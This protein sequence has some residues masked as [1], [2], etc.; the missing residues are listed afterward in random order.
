MAKKDERGPVRNP[1]PRR[2]TGLNP[3]Q[4]AF[5][6][7]FIADPDA[8]QAYVKAGYDVKDE[9]VAASAGRRLLLNVAVLQAI[10][11][12]RLA[13]MKRQSLDADAVVQRYYAL[14][15][16]ATAEKDWTAACMALRDVAKIGGLFIKHQEGKRQ[17]TQA[18]AERLRKELE[19]KGFDLVRYGYPVEMMTPAEVAEDVARL[20]EV[21]ARAERRLAEL[22]L[23]AGNRRALLNDLGAGSN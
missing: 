22:N 12:G 2:E 17:Y 13:V 16:Q 21:K 10:E 4:K 11:E 23:A 5:V 15:L 8:G 1:T 6:S 19:E 7:H 9:A 18:D 20:E 3:R 14:Y